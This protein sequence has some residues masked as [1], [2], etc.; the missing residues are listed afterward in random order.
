MKEKEN[1]KIGGILKWIIRLA[2]AGIIVYAILTGG[3]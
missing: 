2:L 3:G 1:Y